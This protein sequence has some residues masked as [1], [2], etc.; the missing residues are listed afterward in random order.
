M[1]SK[2]TYTLEREREREKGRETSVPVLI[3]KA[4]HTRPAR[5]NVTGLVLL[6]SFRDLA[7]VVISA[8]GGDSA[9]TPALRLKSF[10]HKALQSTLPDLPFYNIIL[11]IFTK[12]LKFCGGKVLEYVIEGWRWGWRGRGRRGLAWRKY[13]MFA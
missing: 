8:D 2:D 7:C 1:L 9:E 5:F 3:Q 12:F 13:A 6:A 11:R 4:D 10:F